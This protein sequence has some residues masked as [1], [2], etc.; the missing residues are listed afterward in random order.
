MAGLALARWLGK[1]EAAGAAP[2]GDPVPDVVL[3]AV[4]RERALGGGDVILREVLAE[5]VLHGWMQNRYQVLF[6]LTVSLRTMQPGRAALLTSMMAAA[7]LAG[8]GA[9]D[10][11]M[12][13]GRVFL[14]AAGGDAE[15]VAA[16]EQALADPPALSTVVVGMME[17]GM[18]AYA[19]V[20]ALVVLDARDA[21]GELFLQYLALRLGLP[22]AVVRS[23]NR[24][25]RR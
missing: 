2:A 9:I 16:F 11:P 21:V 20:A 13:R 5:K 12:E 4:R 22:T 24:R 19:Y 10:G 25:Y 1:R 15:A 18:G 3:P 23:A 8:G 7:A 6:P 17:A 14:R